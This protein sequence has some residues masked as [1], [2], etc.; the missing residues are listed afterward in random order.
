MERKRGNIDDYRGIHIIASDQG[1]YH[2]CYND[3]G[4]LLVYVPVCLE[5]KL[6]CKILEGPSGTWS[7]T[8]VGGEDL[9]NGTTFE[10]LQ[11]STFD[12]FVETDTEKAIE[13]FLLITSCPSLLKD[14]ED[15]T[16]LTMSMKNFCVP[17]FAQKNNSLRKI[18]DDAFRHHLDSK[19]GLYCIEMRFAEAD[20]KDVQHD[21]MLIAKSTRLLRTNKNE[22]NLRDIIARENFR[23]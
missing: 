23:I 8:V 14:C 19:Y 21:E 11:E 1:D 5:K 13:I 7:T 17:I 10:M 18:Q 2:S 22:I 20:H 6:A 16:Y 4:D 12:L 3:D 15:L 9:E